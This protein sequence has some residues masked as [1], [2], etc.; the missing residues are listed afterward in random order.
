MFSS[1]KVDRPVAV[2]GPMARTGS[3]KE[4]ADD[5]TY[6]DDNL[7]DSVEMTADSE[8]SSDE[9]D[10]ESIPDFRYYPQEE[11]LDFPQQTANDQESAVE[12]NYIKVSPS[13]T[14]QGV[15]H[16]HRNA[17]QFNELLAY[18]D[19]DHDVNVITKNF[20]LS[21][22]VPDRFI[23]L[24]AE[25]RLKVSIQLAINHEVFDA[26]FFVIDDFIHRKPVLLT[27]SRWRNVRHLKLAHNYRENGNNLFG[28]IFGYQFFKFIDLRKTLVN[29]ASL[30]IQDTKLGWIV[31][32]MSRKT[33]L[34]IKFMGN[35]N[36]NDSD[37]EEYDPDAPR[38]SNFISNETGTSFN[39]C[40]VLNYQGPRTFFH[41]RRPALDDGRFRI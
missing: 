30:L 6:P 19:F 37:T 39:P 1:A 40:E 3:K 10:G 16:D 28:A 11:Y 7:E 12:R 14:V 27:G 4:I 31:S 29:D 25:N 32:G 21:R 34:P 35:T 20:L 2:V 26:E 38:D 5:E 17:W 41:R 36:D 33:D 8:E 15:I 23:K 9:S 18:I 24:D 22:R 13:V